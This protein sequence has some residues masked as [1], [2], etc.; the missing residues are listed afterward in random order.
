MSKALRMFLFML[1]LVLTGFSVENPKAKSMN[2]PRRENCKNAEMVRKY[3]SI[4]EFSNP[5]KGKVTW[6]G[7]ASMEERPRVVRYSIKSS[8]QLLTERY[9]LVQF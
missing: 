1:L 9:H 4:L 6:Y 7:P 3:S 5:R 8:S 2:L